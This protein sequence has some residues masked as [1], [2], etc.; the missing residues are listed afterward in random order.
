MEESSHVPTFKV[1]FVGPTN[2]GKTSILTR[3]IKNVFSPQSTVPTTSMQ[4]H[5]LKCQTDDGTEIQLNFW[6]TAGQEHFKSLGPMYYRN[7]AYCVAVFELTSSDSFEHMK[8]YIQMF[9]E[10][11]EGSN[12]ITIVGNKRDLEHDSQFMVKVLEWAESNGYNLVLT[13]ALSGDGI[14]DLLQQ[15]IDDLAPKVN[16]EQ[17]SIENIGITI[18]DGPPK[19]PGCC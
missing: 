12:N 2:V 10:N 9:K 17:K 14:G 1:T 11:T 19:K 8:D 18:R 15:I 4:C 7:A 3:L 5:T 6:D 13:S 16:E